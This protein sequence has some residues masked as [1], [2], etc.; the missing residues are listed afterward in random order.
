LSKKLLTAVAPPPIWHLVSPL[1]F[2]FRKKLSRSLLR[3]E[4]SRTHVAA[5]ARRIFSRF[6]LGQRREGRRRSLG[7]GG[8]RRMPVSTV[9][10]CRRAGPLVRRPRQGAGGA[11]GCD[12]EAAVATA[13]RSQA[14]TAGRRRQPLGRGWRSVG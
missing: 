8:R 7:P 12:K 3:E 2:P 9:R 5:R 11:A 1:T 4:G 14:A 13:R 10:C 6:H